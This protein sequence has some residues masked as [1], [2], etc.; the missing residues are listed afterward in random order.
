M[1]VEA[2]SEGHVLAEKSGLGIENLHSFIDKEE[3]LDNEPRPHVPARV[4]TANTT[5][6]E[7]YDPTR[8]QMQDSSREQSKSS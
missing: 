1:M 2:L 3:R 6:G 5:H 4:L 8:F 7:I